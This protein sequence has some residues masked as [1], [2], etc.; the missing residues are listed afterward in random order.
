M[1]EGAARLLNNFISRDLIREAPF[2]RGMMWIKNV[3]TAAELALS[4]FHA[5]FESL[6]TVGSNVGLGLNK[7]WNR[8]ILRGDRQAIESGIKDILTAP[9]SPF[10][11]ARSGGKA[12][13]YL[14]EPEFKNTPEAQAFMRQYPQAEQ[15]LNDLFIGGGKLAMHQDYKINSIKTMK[16]NFYNNNYIGAA[17]RAIPAINETLMKPL[18]EIYIPRLK[19]GQ[20]LKEYSS[21]LEQYA[22]AL[23]SGETT[24]AQL[25]SKTWDFVEDRLGEMNFDNLFWNRTFKSAMQ[26]MFRSVTWKLGNIRAMGGA[27]SGQS[28]EFIN[29]MREQRPPELHSNMAWLIGMTATTVA[30]ATAIQYIATGKMPTNIKDYVYPQIDPDDQDIRVSIPTY[31][32]DIVSLAHSP[33]GYGKSSLSSWVGRVADIWENK[34]FYGTEVRHPGDNPFNQGLEVAA[35]MIPLPFSLQ[36]RSRLQKEGESEIKQEAGFLGFTKAPGYLSMTDAEKIE[37]DFLRRHMSAE[38][39]TSAEAEHSELLKAFHRQVAKGEMG[40]LQKALRDRDISIKEYRTILRERKVAAIVHN[41][42]NLK[43]EEGI[44]V[45]KASNAEEKKLLKVMLIRKIKNAL[46]NRPPEER[47]QLLKELKALTGSAASAE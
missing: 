38:S 2:G 37:Q 10:F 1:D 19:V 25:A 40:P 28:M 27:A 17:I 45:Y 34:D 4:L 43:A 22:G 18:F 46:S 11:V 21:A 26:L 7:I 31:W 42:R 15:L 32:K 35:H 29:A 41:F 20:F 16:E 33:M 36:S 13:R 24:R 6:E 9:V 44:D 8:G 5:T 3:T 30:L 12:I 14:S 23:Q 47:E 39:R